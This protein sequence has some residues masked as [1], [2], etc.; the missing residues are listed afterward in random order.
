MRKFFPNLAREL[1]EYASLSFPLSSKDE[2]AK[3]PISP[4]YASYKPTV[5]DFIRRCDSDSQALEIILFLERRGEISKE[6]AERL[7][8][9]LSNFGVRSFGSKKRP[10]WYYSSDPYF[11]GM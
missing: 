1:E 4:K 10:G 6:C 11:K 2:A 7:K 3:H 5:I 8:E 9:Q